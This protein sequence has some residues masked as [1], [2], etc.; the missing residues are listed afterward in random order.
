MKRIITLAVVAL[1][2][3]GSTKASEDVKIG[4]QN[5]SVKDGLMTPEA[6]WAMG[7]IGGCSA[8][9]DGSKIVYQVGYYS[10]K[11]NKSHQV[12]YIMNADG[13]NQTLLT[14]SDKNETD[15]AWIDAE[16]IATF[17]SRTSRHISAAFSA[18]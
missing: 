14:K 1:L 9:P 16:T 13:S 6:L 5:I 12:L 2:A 18:G 10:V 7:R 8:S 11:H 15:A 4:K 3:A 17:S